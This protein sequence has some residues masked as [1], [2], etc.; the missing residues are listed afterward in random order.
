MVD[1]SVDLQGFFNS[2]EVYGKYSACIFI[3]NVF[4]YRRINGV[5]SWSIEARGILT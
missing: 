1:E 5:K 2:L 3:L 4:H